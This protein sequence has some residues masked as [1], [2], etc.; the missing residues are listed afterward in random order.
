MPEYV[1][2]VSFNVVLVVRIVVVYV[3]VMDNEELMSIA[4]LDAEEVELDPGWFGGREAVTP[5][6]SEEEGTAVEYKIEIVPPGGNP[7]GV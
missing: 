3:H 1:G 4:V 6:A 5:P 7:V 2:V